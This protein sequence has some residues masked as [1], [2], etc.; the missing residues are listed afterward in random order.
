MTF[1]FLKIK[2][3]YA[4]EKVCKSKCTY[5]IELISEFVYIMKLYGQQRKKSQ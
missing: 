2:S 4:K 1:L 5:T 3:F